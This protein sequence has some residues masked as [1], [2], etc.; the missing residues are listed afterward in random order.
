MSQPASPSSEVKP[1]SVDCVINGHPE[2]IRFSPYFLD[3]ERSVYELNQEY[4]LDASGSLSQDFVPFVEGTTEHLLLDVIATGQV[5]RLATAG[6]VLNER[7]AKGQ[8]SRNLAVFDPAT[9][10]SYTLGGI[11]FIA[12]N[13]QD[14]A[15]FTLKDPLWDQY[16]EDYQRVAGNGEGGT[17]LVTDSGFETI[18]NKSTV[19]AMEYNSGIY[20][21]VRK[22]QENEAMRE[23][24]INAPQ[25]IAAGAISNLQ[26]GRYGFTIYRGHF[27]PEYLL[28][29][30]LY[31][32][33][34]ANF[35][36]NYQAYL[37][38]KYQQLA[39]MHRTLKQSHGQPSINNTLAEIKIN[40]Q[41]GNL[42]CQI[43]D[44]QTNRPLPTSTDKTLEDGICPFPIGYQSKKSPRVAAM[45]Y[46]LQHALTQEL[47]ILFVPSRFIKDPQEKFNY[48][49]NQSARLLG[50]VAQV[51][52]ICASDVSHQAIDFAV[53]RYFDALKAG[54]V[55]LDNFNELI[56]GVFVH[57]WFALSGRYGN[58]V[59]LSDKR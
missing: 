22:I 40:E 46:D 49:T 38:S 13:A 2:T 47:N 41:E 7:P 15:R 23:Q 52:E 16:Y 45:I 34:G 9:G 53:H 35:K 57:K 21:I 37:S 18:A 6:L 30:N 39:H 20:P 44:F 4:G 51:Y 8:I 27:T 11:G 5:E 58:E 26:N 33:A 29:V 19:G 36:K 42:S 32:D 1:Y 12:P 54:K 31:L 56:A 55:S 14:S 17:V 48:L 3:S 43:K 10:L 28:N 59:E 24:G 25:Y 50:V